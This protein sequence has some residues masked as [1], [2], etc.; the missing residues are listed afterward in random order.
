MKHKWRYNDKGS[1][2]PAQPLQDD[3][4]YWEKQIKTDRKGNEYIQYFFRYTYAYNFL[5]RRGFGR[6]MMADGRFQ[7][8]HIIDKIVNIVEPWYIRDFMMEFTKGILA[9]QKEDFVPV[10]DMLYR[11]GKMYYGPDSLS[12]VDFVYPAFEYAYK[13]FQYLFFK[14][15]YWKVTADGIE[16]KPMSDLQHYVWKENVKNASVSL[17]N[18]DLISVELIDEAFLKKYKLDNV[19]NKNLMGQFD[20]ELS[21]EAHDSH[22]IQYLINTGEFFWQKFQDPKTRKRGNDSRSKEERYETNLHLVSKMTAIG[23]LLHRYN[24]SSC[25]K[26]VIGM[27]GKLSEV[28]ES[29]GRTG[30]SLLGKALKNIISEVTIGAKSRDL[31]NDQFL[32][33]EVSEKTDII[34]LDDCRPNLDFEFFFPMITGQLT[35]NRKGQ[36]KF[37]LDGYTPKL[38]ITTNHAINGSSSSFKD[39]QALIAFS[40]YYNESWKPVDEF[41]INFFDEWDE[42]QWNLF[43]NFMAYCLVLYFRAQKLGWG[44]NHSGLIQPPTERLEKRRLRQFI[45]EDFLTWAGEFFNVDQDNVNSIET[46]RMNDKIPRSE[47]YNSFLEKTPT[48]R[49]FITPQRFK[50]KMIAWCDYMK[51]RFNPASTGKNGVPHPGGDDKSGGIEFFT[52]AND[53]FT[54]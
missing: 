18:K 38:Y 1:L 37:T 5:K 47:L 6:I 23:Y 22:F 27:D 40:D 44:I 12:N 24:D 39:R 26:A 52:I 28:G 2:E 14:D 11:G 32:F 48:Q 16:E 53:R 45:G 8:C 50:K 9:S 13:N 33:E 25:E 4:Q 30:K 51:L 34:F 31:E 46:T 49:K 29:N 21:P 42:K 19:D 36:I 20:I 10:M 41:G 43:F 35:I 17:I 3:E 7:L 15:K 54:E